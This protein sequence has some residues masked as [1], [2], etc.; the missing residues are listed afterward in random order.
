[1]Q[2]LNYKARF[3]RNFLRTENSKNFAGKL[4]T[5]TFSV[6]SKFEEVNGKYD[7]MIT[8]AT[9]RIDNQIKINTSKD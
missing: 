8:D 4:K 1:M 2:A 7:H 9:R 5:I 6:W 3:I